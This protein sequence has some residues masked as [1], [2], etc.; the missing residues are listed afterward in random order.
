LGRHL[1][2]TAA[3]ALHPSLQKINRH[4]KMWVA[5]PYYKICKCNLS[6]LTWLVFI[7]LQMRQL[8]INIG[9]MN[10]SAPINNLSSYFVQVKTN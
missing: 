2:N 5:I 9:V 3:S 6:V 7:S 4:T 10:V 1:N 8:F